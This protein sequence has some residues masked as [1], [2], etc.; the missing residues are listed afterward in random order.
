MRVNVIMPQLGESV[1]EGT[2]VKWLKKVGDPIQRDENILEI[3]TDKVDSEIPAPASGI[4][5]EILAQEGETIP[6]GKPIAVIETDVAQAK[7]APVPPAKAPAEQKTEAPAVAYGAEPGATRI[8]KRPAAG[9]ASEAAPKRFLS[10]L[11]KSIAQAEGITNEELDRITGTGAGGRLTKSD[12][13]NYLEQRKSRPKPMAARPAAVLP[14][15]AAT[16]APAPT[17]G[18]PAIPGEGEEV[19]PMD[20]MRRRIAEHMVKSAFTAPHVT[21][22]SEADMTNI[23]A[24]RE[25]LKSSFEAR[26][27]YKLT[28]TPIIIEC[29]I[30]ALKDYPYLNSSI[31]GENIILKHYIN[32]G[33]AVALENG[34]IVPVIKGADGMNLR[35]LA[36][37]VNDLSVRARTKRLSPDD[38]HGSTFSITN[39]GIF[40]NLF[41]TPIIN[42]PNVAILGLGAIV[43]RPVVIEGDA[44]TIRSMMYLSLSYDH[45]IIDGA[46]GGQFLQRVVHY[47]ENFDP[48]TTI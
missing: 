34:L 45:R 23:V 33:I 37:A 38:V 29:V 11:V 13:Q 47:L 48:K 22:V 39:P 18:I 27:G 25:R 42:Q 16:P 36:K 19:I 43:K 8:V 46:L 21:S 26:E 28:Y 2:I 4:L 32:M 35:S 41:G 12:L 7:A 6:I 40:G 24:F 10:P 15:A 17:P 14:P 1:A 9:K 44:I 5:V 20:I 30:K 3:S 31:D